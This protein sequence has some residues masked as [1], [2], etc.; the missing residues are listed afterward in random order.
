MRIGFSKGRPREVR[1]AAQ[2]NDALGGEKVA[3]EHTD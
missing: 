3:T 2:M 1:E